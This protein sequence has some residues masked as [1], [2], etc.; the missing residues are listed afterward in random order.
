MTQQEAIERVL[1]LA[2]NEIG[3]HEKA[4]N[5]QL[6][7][8]TANSGAANWTKYAR[9]LDSISSF[10]NGKKNG[11]MWCDMFVDW[12]LV[13]SFG[14]ETGRKMLCQPLNSS[15]AGCLYS[16]R[17]YRSAGRWFTTPQP[18]DQIFFSFSSGE[19]S[20]TG[21]V[22]SVSSTT[23]TTIEGN[24]SDQVA[25][26]SYARSSG[27]IYGYGRPNWDLV[28][29]N[30]ATPTDDIDE[31]TIPAKQSGDTAETYYVY[32]SRILKKGYA[33]TDVKE[34]QTRLIKLGYSLPR[35]GA[36]GEF[37]SETYDALISFQRSH[38]IETDGEAGKDTYAAIDKALKPSGSTP[39]QAQ[40]TPWTPALG[41][42]V[43]FTGDKHYVSANSAIGITCRGGTAKITAI[44]KLGTAKHPYHLV[45]VAGG[46]SNVYGWV[47]A[48]AISKA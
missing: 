24:T 2:R 7:S 15:G 37:G 16:S 38:G 13:K 11:F 33:G 19:V 39:A 43:R 23:V 12:L 8:K 22:E 17:Y 21:I 31:A 26:R 44:Y 30:A 9:D 18:G 40:V 20:H 35:Y 1:A 4:S 36:D 5:S 3:Y 27:V 47:D 41:D 28:A 10:Y 45:A 34:L 46:G 32:G 14:A 25:R 42:I 6:D 29:G 48:N